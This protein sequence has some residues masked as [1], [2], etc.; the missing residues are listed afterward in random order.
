[1]LLDQDRPFGLL[2]KAFFRVSRT[3]YL[4]LKTI[5]YRIVT[6]SLDK[7]GCCVCYVGD[8]ESWEGKE[9]YF[10]LPPCKPPACQR[11][12]SN[13][14]QF[15]SWCKSKGCVGCYQKGEHPAGYLCQ[16]PPASI[17]SQPHPAFSPIL[18]PL[19]YVSQQVLLSLPLSAGTLQPFECQAR[20]VWLCV[21]PMAIKHILPL[22]C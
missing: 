14:C 1:M 13:P 5:S 22:E 17:M 19:T 15:F 8:Q 4:D 3:S 9:K 6:R 7:T 11:V 20:H 2:I 16:V 10:L 12:S 21:L 18:P